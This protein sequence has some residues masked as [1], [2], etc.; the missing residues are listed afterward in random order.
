[1]NQGSPDTQL[2]MQLM[3]I[4]EIAAAGFSVRE[5]RTGGGVTVLKN[6]AYFGAWRMSMGQL[7]WVSANT[8]AP[9]EPCETVDEAARRTLLKIL[10]D[11]QVSATKP[12]LKKAV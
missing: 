2:R 8:A 1:M 9:F 5:G 11:L 12:A 7:T 3:Q 4:P 6:G 10:R